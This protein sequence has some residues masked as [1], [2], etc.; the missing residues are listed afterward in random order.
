MKIYKF[1]HKDTATIRI[2]KNDVEVNLLVGSDISTDDAKKKLIERAHLI[3]QRIRNKD[4]IEEYDADIKEFIE[5]E[6]DEKNIVTVCRYGA[7]VLN[8]DQYSFYDLDDYSHSILDLFGAVRRMS[9]KQRIVHKFKQNISKYPELGRSFRI[10]ETCNGIR[11]IGKKYL[12]PNASNFTRIM[13]ALNV[14]FTYSTLCRKQNCYRARLTPKPFRM[15][16]E[17]IK[18]KSPLDCETSNYKSWANMYRSE[19]K[20]YSVVKLLETIGED[21]ASDKTIQFHDQTANATKN[22]KLV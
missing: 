17:T 20:A 3:E 12:D 7:L 19:S 18:I 9:K 22:Q 5:S 13:R 1:W 2:D 21:F 6:I 10:Y 8:S 15:K 16:I 11:V 4:G 14:D